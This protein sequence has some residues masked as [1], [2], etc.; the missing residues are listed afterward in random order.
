MDCG[1]IRPPRAFGS[2][3]RRSRGAQSG[4]RF[5]SDLHAVHPERQPHAAMCGT[6]RMKPKLVC[7]GYAGSSTSAW[8]LP[9][10]AK[11]CLYEIRRLVT[12][13]R[14]LP[15]EPTVAWENWTN[16]PTV[17][18]ENVPNEP[19]VA[20]ENV[21]NVPTVAQLFRRSH[22]RRACNLRYLRARR[23]W[24]AKG[25]CDRTIRQFRMNPF[26]SPSAPHCRGPFLRVA[27][28]S[29]PAPFLFVRSR[30]LTWLSDTEALQ[31]RAR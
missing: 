30:F 24:I 18:W 15:N 19:T 25:Q 26:N 5:T 20:W 27:G 16:E 8:E 22:A 14:K 9:N 28:A 12:K 3:A 29:V 10:E 7:I 17:A 21:T 1:A 11:V 23:R 4:R 2:G 13:V 31:N 6:S